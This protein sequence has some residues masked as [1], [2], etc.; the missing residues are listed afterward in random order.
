MDASWDNGCQTH[1]VDCECRHCCEG[2]KPNIALDYWPCVVKKK[3]K[4]RGGGV[5]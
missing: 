2:S 5:T 1:I 3:K 4:K